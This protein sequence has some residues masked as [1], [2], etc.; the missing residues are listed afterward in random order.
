MKIFFEDKFKELFALGKEFYENKL[1]EKFPDIS[2]IISGKSPVI[3]YGAGRMGK[4]FKTNLAKFGVDIIAFVDSNPDLWGRDIEGIKIISPKE[5]IKNYS[6]KPILIASLVY[7]TEIYEKLSRMQFHLIY[8]LYFLNYKYPNIFVSPEYF[9][10]FNSLFSL[11]NQSDILK[12]SKL[13]EDE[14]SKQVFFNLIKFRLTFNK[15]FIKTIKTNNKQ[16]F[17]PNILSFEQK[18]VFLDC[19][20]YTG[21]SIEQF[22]KEV[23]GKFKKIYSFEPDQENFL[24]LC[25]TIRKINSSQ[26]IPV[27]KAVYSSTK[28][29]K[30]CETNDVD[31]RIDDKNS[32][33]VFISAISIDDFL[34]NKEEATFIKMDI[35]GAEIEALLGAKKVIRKSKPKLAISVYHKD[36]DLWKIPLLIKHLNKNY[37]LYLRHYSNEITDTVCYAI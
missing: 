17:E 21:D 30:F 35:E 15:F 25:Q 28:E 16:Y 11:K 23:S 8:P 36:L 6:S 4:M 5:L 1:Q 2:L 34:K 20:A 26:I 18:E 10:K 9:Q 33:S 19:G 13:W 27:D 3:I 12:I 22:C 7:E 24:K 29:I 37:R 31:A 32:N 14:Q